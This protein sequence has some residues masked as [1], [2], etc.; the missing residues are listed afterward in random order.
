MRFCTLGF[1][2]RFP[3]YQKRSFSYYCFH[4]LNRDMSWLRPSEWHEG[5]SR[6]E[7][8]YQY[9]RRRP[10]FRSSNW[11]QN[12]FVFHNSLAMK[13]R[14]LSIFLAWSLP[15]EFHALDGAL[16]RGVFP[17]RCLPPFFGNVCNECH[18]WHVRWSTG[19]D[20]TRQISTGQIINR[21]PISK[22]G[23]KKGALYYL[24]KGPLLGSLATFFVIGFCQ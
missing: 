24:Q 5:R 15:P 16:F 20:R 8:Q 1:F 2:I 6:K 19:V 7:R 23:Y 3:R 12:R 22:Q 21:L 11:P 13:Y 4:P 17:V 10:T 18:F 14:P 9:W